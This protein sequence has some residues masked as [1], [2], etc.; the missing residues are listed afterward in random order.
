M[1]KKTIKLA[2]YKDNTILHGDDARNGLGCECICLVCNER[3]Q[4]VHPRFREAHF[5]HNQDMECTGGPETALHLY[6]KQIIIDNHQIRLP[7]KLLNYINPLSEICLGACR[8]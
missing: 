1:H 5:R 6:A 3:L 7:G 4:A 2:K 8:T